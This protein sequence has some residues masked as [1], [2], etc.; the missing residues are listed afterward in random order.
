M[1]LADRL[2]VLVINEIP[3]VGLDFSNAA[4]NQ[5]LTA[6]HLAQCQRALGELI[7]RDKN[8]P[9]TIMW[10]VANEPM[11]GPPLGIGDPPA[12]SV[13][14]GTHFFR[15]MYEDAHQLDGTRPVTY[16]GVQ[17]GPREWHG[18]FDVICLNGY[19]GWYS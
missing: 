14:T 8:H 3:A 2:G 7:A 15:Q 5:A 11:A 10:S 1:Q 12:G 16:V 18:I 9:S 19:Y 17:G 13:E 6:E 4:Y